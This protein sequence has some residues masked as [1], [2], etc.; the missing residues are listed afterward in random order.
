R[1]A[2]RTP[3]GRITLLSFTAR[4]HG[5]NQRGARQLLEKI[6]AT[7]GEVGERDFICL[8]GACDDVIPP[9]ASS[10]RTGKGELRAWRARTPGRPPRAP[11]PGSA[12]AQRI[13]AWRNH[14]AASSP[15]FQPPFHGLAGF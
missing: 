12:C 7:C 3:S 8:A 5:R 15:D 10:R 11:P 13:A 6:Y 14:I 1:R 4:P 9:V 2:G